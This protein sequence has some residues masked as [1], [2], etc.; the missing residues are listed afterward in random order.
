MP[1]LTAN[2]IQKRFGTV[3]ALSDARLEVEPRQIHGL[4]GPNGSGKSTLM[5]V[6]AG[7][8]L[9]DA[10]SVVLDGQDITRARPSDRARRGLSIKFQLARV[11]RDQTVEENL[12]LALQ[13]G[14][15]MAGLILSRSR[16]RL[17]SD[18]DRILGDFGLM[19]VRHRL[20]GELSHGE[21]QWLEIAMA[22]A[23]DPTV[24]LLDEPTGGM[25]RQERSR[26][27]EL[28]RAAATRCAVVIIEHDLDFI[29][30]LC[31]RITVLHQ[32]QWVATGTPAEI[33]RDPRVAE[34]YLTRV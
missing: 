32:G 23:T 28:I 31:D 19:S 26:T 18:I 1:I 10:G 5:H 33:E 27:G 3:T 12:L 11:Y 6:I 20:A 7:R 29:R 16:K 21:Q 13:V 22:M 8:T 17:R 24:I 15:S 4:I 9:P 14:T 25:S 2:S 34:V 30:E